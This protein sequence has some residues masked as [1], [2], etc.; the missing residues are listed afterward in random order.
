MVSANQYMELASANNPIEA[1]L[2][3]NQFVGGLLF[4]VIVMIIVFV[5]YISAKN[6]GADTISS[7]IA[8]TFTGFLLSSLLFVLQWNG[9]PGVPVALP[10]IMLLLTATFIGLKIW[11][12]D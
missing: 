9:L 6:G 11:R 4:G 8:S 12:N 2:V 10:I 7:M 3:A 1:F 5:V